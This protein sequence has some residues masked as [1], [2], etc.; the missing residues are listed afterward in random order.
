M[1]AIT[2]H[3]LETNSSL[4]SATLMSHLVEYIQSRCSLQSCKRRRGSVIQI[5][6]QNRETWLSAAN[7][8]S[9]WCDLNTELHRL[10][11][12]RKRDAMV[13]YSNGNVKLKRME[14]ELWPHTPSTTLCHP[15][16]AMARNESRSSPWGRSTLLSSAKL[17]EAGMFELDR[18]AR[19]AFELE[20]DSDAIFFAMATEKMA[21]KSGRDRSPSIPVAKLSSLLAS[22][23]HDQTNQTQTVRALPPIPTKISG[24]FFLLNLGPKTCLPLPRESYCTWHCSLC[25]A[26]CPTPVLSAPL[27]SHGACRWR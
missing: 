20:F 25:V 6:R 10:R 9:G 19:Y 12:V 24:L 27:E 1:I 5:S 13:A 15:P 21:S 11:Q 2:W 14:K 23:L 26:E 8:Q 7:S 3:S 22:Q 18:D 4:A 16:G 17:V